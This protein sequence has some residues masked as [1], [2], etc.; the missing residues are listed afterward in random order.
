MAARL[1]RPI[2]STPFSAF[3]WLKFEAQSPTQHL[4]PAMFP[5]MGPKTD[6]HL[7]MTSRLRMPSVYTGSDFPVA[8]GLRSNL[9]NPALSKAGVRGFPEPSQLEPCFWPV[10]PTYFIQRGE[11]E[12]SRNPHNLNLALARRANLLYP[13][14]E[15][16]GS[17]GPSQLEPCFWP[18]GPTHFIQRGER[19]G[20]RNPHNLNLAL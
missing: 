20:S 1:A 16:E 13:K 7:L 10:G 17:R 2:L 5:S 14:G 18:V 19:E 3:P 12:G 8:P 11:R 15:C 9:K 4:N 6:C